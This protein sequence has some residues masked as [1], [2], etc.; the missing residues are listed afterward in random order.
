MIPEDIIIT[1]ESFQQPSFTYKIDFKKKKVVGTID[2][3]EAVK[4]AVFLILSTERDYS[5]I[6]QDYGIKIIDMI[7][8]DFPFVVSELKK[9]ITETLKGDDRITEVEEFTFTY[10]DDGLLVEFNVIT[11]YGVFHVQEVYNL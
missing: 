2:G 9:R 4:Q 1:A 6:Y 11:I 10:S 3:L 5:E 7:G 8:K